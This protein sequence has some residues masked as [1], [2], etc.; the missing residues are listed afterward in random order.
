MQKNIVPQETYDEIKDKIIAKQKADLRAP[1][2]AQ[3]ASGA[4][5][6]RGLHL[7]GD[8]GLGSAVHRDE[9]C[10]A[11]GTP[12]YPLLTSPASASLASSVAGSR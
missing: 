1:D 2:A 6:S 10:T 8:M 7:N 9:R 11:S 4:L 12:T 3:R 5:Q